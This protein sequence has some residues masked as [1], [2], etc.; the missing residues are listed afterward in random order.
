MFKRKTQLFCCVVSLR[1]GL[2]PDVPLFAVSVFGIKLF[3]SLAF[4]AIPLDF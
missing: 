2:F 3:P 1:V 4:R